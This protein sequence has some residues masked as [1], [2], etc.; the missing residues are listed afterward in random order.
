MYHEANVIL[1]DFSVF[2]FIFYA[3]ISIL[4]DLDGSAAFA[5]SKGFLFSCTITV[6][7]V[8][9]AVVVSLV[10]GTSAKCNR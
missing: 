6:L 5:T 4:G 2:T 3:W 9:V 8:N 1:A 7:S 10:V